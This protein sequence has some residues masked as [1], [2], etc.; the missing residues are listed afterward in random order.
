MTAITETSTRDRLI[1]AAIE[2]FWERG[3]DGAG[4]QEIARRAGLT[5]GAIYG[6]FRG[7]A[8]LLFE[9]IDARGDNEL[10]ELFNA[11]LAS[12]RAGDFLADLGS[13]LLDPDPTSKGV[14]LMEAFTA[15]RRDPDLSRLVRSLIDRRGSSLAALIERAREQGDIGD[16]VSTDALA[17]FSL[18][19]ALGSLLFNALGLD[20]PDEQEWSS[21]IRRLV[22]AL[23][24]DESE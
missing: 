17:R 15:A 22:D 21:L 13:H 19:L 16:G 24:E 4:V 12:G 9:S 2:V 8:D 5:T 18:V 23:E 6:K 10:D 11:Q 14:L 3:Y 1:E 7:K 20:R